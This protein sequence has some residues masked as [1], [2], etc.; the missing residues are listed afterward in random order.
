MGI[1]DGKHRRKNRN[2]KLETRYERESSQ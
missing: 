1:H 2:S